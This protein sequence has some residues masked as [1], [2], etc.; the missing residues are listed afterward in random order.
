MG[1]S[2][3]PD[4]GRNNPFRTVDWRWQRAA[5]LITQKQ[6]FS[7]KRD[8][9]LVGRAV[10]F[11]R[12]AQR[13]CSDLGS[14]RLM[15]HFPEIVLALKCHQ[16]PPVKRLELECRVLGRQPAELI[17]EMLEAPLTFIQAFKHYFFD[18][19]D[20]IDASSYIM[21]Q[22]I[23]GPVRG[24]GEAEKWMKLFV[25]H[26]GPAAIEPWLD[27]L[28]HRDEV[29]DLKTLDG[30]QRD[31]IAIFLKAQDL[32][33]DGE[34]I[35]KALPFVMGSWRENRVFQS[36]SSLFREMA[37]QELP[38]LSWREPAAAVSQR[39]SR[40]VKRRTGRYSATKGVARAG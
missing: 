12:H 6:N 1:F 13:V 38:R 22:V 26:R 15:R 19:D 2:W 4:Q 11:M 5:W 25:Y 10:N 27:F 32:S 33:N 29:H 40:L 21:H 17:A 35:L 28:R 7:C 18:I 20:R 23:C 24:E 36:A 30:W 14:R 8:D 31:A 34:D 3:I 37:D 39:L 9:E 16:G